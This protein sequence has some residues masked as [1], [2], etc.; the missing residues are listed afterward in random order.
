M[1]NDLI[2]IFPYQLASITEISTDFAVIFFKVPKKLFMDTINGLGRLTLDYFFYMRKYYSSPLSEE[3][4]KSFVLFCHILSCRVVLSCAFLSSES[5]M[6]FLRVYYWDLYVGYKSNPKAMAS[7]KFVRKEKQVFEFF[8]LV[9]EYHTISRDVA[10]YAD[11][12]CISPK[13]L[14]MLITDNTGRSAKEWIVEYT[15]LEIKV[16]LK[17][18]NLEIKEVVSRTNFQSNSTMTRFFRK[19]TG[20]TP[21]E[22]RERMFV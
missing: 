18:S 3:E 4:Y 20:T 17:D 22:Y 16:L 13:Y 10:F 14:T 12:M 1:K 21:S 8:Y 15:I 2:T 19:H 9:I 11:K 5:V 7:V 6:Y